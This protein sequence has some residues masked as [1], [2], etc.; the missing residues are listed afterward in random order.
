M[1]VGE[2]E[3]IVIK[4][5]AETQQ[6]MSSMRESQEATKHLA[7]S[8]HQS[9]KSMSDNIE[10]VDQSART[11]GYTMNLLKSS[12]ASLGSVI[13][14]TS[15]L[16]KAGEFEKTTIAFET[17]L[18]SAQEAKAILSELTRFAAETPFEMPEIEQAARGLIQFGER[19]KD[20]METLKILGN[21]AAGTSTDFS[22]IALIFN[23][24][25]GVGK[26]MTQDFRQLSTRGVISL[27]DIAKQF[28]TNTEGAQRMLSEG[29]VS[30]EDLRKIFKSLSADGGRFANL[31]ER[32]SKSFSGLWSTLKDDFGITMRTLG[33]ELLP[34]AKKLLDEVLKITTWFRNLNDETKRMIALAL[35]AAAAFVALVGALSTASF[36]LSGLILAMA[37]FG[38]GIALV[39]GAVSS[40]VGLMGGWEN[41]WNAVK[42]AANQFW[43]DTKPVFIQLK[44]LAV[45]AFTEIW[46]IVKYVF[47]AIGGYASTLF[48]HIGTTGVGTFKQLMAATLDWLLFTEFTFKNSSQI[49][50]L[51]LTQMQLRWEEFVSKGKYLLSWFGENWKEIFMNAC[52]NAAQMIDNFA[53]NVKE[54]FVA[55]W[56]FIKSGGTA[57]FNPNIRALTEGFTDEI[58]NMPDLTKRVVS[59]AEKALT[60]QVDQMAEKVGQSF[61]DFKKLKEAQKGMLGLPK[62]DLKM[63]ESLAKPPALKA[64]DE[65]DKLTESLKK[66]SHALGLTSFE[67]EIYEL[68][69]KGVTDAQLSQAVAL[70][71]TV[72]AFKLVK[73]VQTPVQNAMDKYEIGLKQIERLLGAGAIDQDTFNKALVKMNK[74]LNDATKKEHEVKLRVSGTETVKAGTKAFYDLI[75][76]TE[77]FNRTR[78]RIR[79]GPIVPPRKNMNPNRPPLPAQP[80]QAVPAQ[81]AVAQPAVAG[82]AAPMAPMAAPV[83]PVAPAPMAPPPAAAPEAGICECLCKCLTEAMEHLAKVL[84]RGTLRDSKEV[85]DDI[86]KEVKTANSPKKAPPSPLPVKL[87][88]PVPMPVR[89]GQPSPP[90]IYASALRTG[91]APTTYGGPQTPPVVGPVAGPAVAPA[92]MPKPGGMLPGFGTRPGFH[93]M[94]GPGGGGRTGPGH[95][96]DRLGRMAERA[97]KEAE[98]MAA[99]GTKDFRTTLDT[100]GLVPDMGWAMGTPKRKRG[101]MGRAMGAHMGPAAQGAV[102]GAVEGVKPSIRMPEMGESGKVP[103]PMIPQ[104]PVPAAPVVPPTPPVPQPA[105]TKEELGWPPIPKHLWQPG[106]PGVPEGLPPVAQ[107][108]P[109]TP[110]PARPAIPPRA[111]S[112]AGIAAARVA[113]DAERS[114]RMADRDAMRAARRTTRLD[115]EANPLTAVQRADARA[116]AA[117]A[118][119]GELARKKSSLDAARI[120]E[121]VK[122]QKGM[123][124]FAGGGAARVQA[125]MAARK[126]LRGEG[127]GESGFKIFA[128]S[129]MDRV[130][131]DVAKRRAAEGAEG[132]LTVG[133]QV[134][135]DMEARMA[136]KRAER[137]RTGGVTARLER[138]AGMRNQRKAYIASQ[139]GEKSPEELKEIAKGIKDLVDLTKKKD[140]K[141]T[142]EPL[143]LE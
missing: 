39:S 124:F 123:N 80:A 115:R 31:M 7:S 57:G 125:A 139:T 99:R 67:A 74:E 20:L 117:A 93:G 69:L 59:D 62:T 78:A 110:A 66:Q 24:V 136:A 46:A 61:D 48:G 118:K 22:M 36:I 15:A 3:S 16:F 51:L 121:N 126:A 77:D 26:L 84:N 107:A 73:S 127:V 137:E 143:G 120:A 83:A 54:V 71:N 75:K 91:G 1:A 108:V 116:T 85:L 58:K 129:A 27:E 113:R 14:I 41:A 132:G 104:E 96:A 53:L 47:S 34:V 5:V 17:M 122:K 64:Q 18:G 6:Y 102:K 11:L 135:K 88:H 9:S 60:K 76:Q 141:L 79:M 45:V 130:R 95:R 86:H 134:G 30:F 29:K 2:L 35:G 101:A 12:M 138:E 19:G 52:L 87:I 89:V 94:G 70:N 44:D 131:R 90:P 33:A 111:K 50:S 21:A 97:A 92:P 114:K 13:G 68:K 10:R 112:D 37:K 4:L 105:G 43:E 109:A 72:E 28:K 8:I 32:Q 140:T 119:Q 100:T 56:K 65:V 133:Q 38:V 142:I 55:L 49:Q 81:A 128:G 63:A 82:M 40:F 23:Q 98:R 25:R 106:Q 103:V 42:D